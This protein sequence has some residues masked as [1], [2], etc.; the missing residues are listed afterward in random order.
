MDAQ[1]LSQEYGHLRPGAV[2]FLVALALSMV[3]TWLSI[4]GARRVGAVKHPRGGD[5]DLHTA[6]IPQLGGLAIFAAYATT[7][8]FLRRWDLVPLLAVLAATAVVF[9]YDDV[10]GIHPWIKL[11]VQLL[12]AG[13]AVVALG[14]EIRFFTVPGAGLVQLGLVGVPISIFWLLGMENTVNFLDGVDGLAAG[15]VGIVACVLVVA[16]AG[17]VQ[18]DQVA[19]AA[20]LAGVCLGFLLFNFHPA[21]LFMGD[22]GAYTLG[23]ALGALSISAVAKVAV[24]FALVVPLL[25]LAIPIL[26]TAWAIVRR[27]RQKLSIAHAD[28]K[29]IHHQLLDFGLSQPQTCLVF[30]CGTGILG[31]LGLMLFGHKRILSIAIVLLLVGLS[32]VVGESLQEAGWRVRVPGLRRLLARPSD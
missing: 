11:A 15:V 22:S 27:R 3:L 6:P 4:V 13:L 5:R 17:R 10:R 18:S 19:A 32:T 21:R 30:Y 9:I 28:T 2:P 29:H 7:V 26:D 20:V 24:V 23:L 1:Y 25:A 8:L 12:I 16:A 31:S 14:Y